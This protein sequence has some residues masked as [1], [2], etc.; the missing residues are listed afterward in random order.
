MYNLQFEQA[1]A[2]FHQWEK[3]HPD[4]P[5][6]PVSDAAAYLFQEFDRLH[7]L[8]SEFFVHD[9]NF[10]KAR[11]LQPDPALKTKFMNAL[12]EAEQ[13]ARGILARSPEDENALFASIL[14]LGLLSDYLAL[15]E[16]R[17]L[18]SLS[19]MKRARGLA[20]TLLRKNPNFYDAYLAIGVENYLL[21]LK[22]A[23]MRWLLRIGGARTNKEEGLRQLRL[24]A[25]RGHYLAPFARLLL[26][27]SAIRD[28]DIGRA[29]GLLNGLATEF[30]LNP[31]Y[32]EELARLR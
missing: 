6:A 25:E 13:K 4:D 31:L 3:L 21:S 16:K 14:R 17:Y 27:V 26:A 7:I 11:K 28:N 30:P 15:I 9:S 24:T 23:P 29:K 20:E 18:A 10:V 19:E 8:Q 32:K 5:L 1:H 12:G 22:A 2:S